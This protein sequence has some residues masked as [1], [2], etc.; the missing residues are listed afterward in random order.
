MSVCRGCDQ[1]ATVLLTLL[2]STSLDAVSESCWPCAA[3]IMAEWAD[4]EH[5]DD[6]EGWSVER[7]HEGSTG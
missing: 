4:S 5:W 7:L 1:P 6:V 3:A 2:E